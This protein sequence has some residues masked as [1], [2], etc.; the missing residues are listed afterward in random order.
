MPVPLPPVVLQTLGHIR[1]QPPPDCRGRPLPRRCSG[2]PA[3]R[4]AQS[5]WPRAPCIPPRPAAPNRDR[6]FQPGSSRKSWRPV[7]G[8]V[9][10]GPRAWRGRRRVN[11]AQ[12]AGAI[13]HTGHGGHPELLARPVPCE[14]GPSLCGRAPCHHPGPP[15]TSRGRQF[16][17]EPTAPR[18]SAPDQALR[19]NRHVGNPALG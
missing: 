8:S 16:S 5:A 18:A 12:E 4:G 19:Q 11:A 1:W 9:R 17:R 7:G 3:A 6:T 14:E 13:P 10:E 2:T 15:Q